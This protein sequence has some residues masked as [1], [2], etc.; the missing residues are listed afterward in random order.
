MT[1]KTGVMLLKIKLCIQRVNYILK[2]IKIEN[3]Y[4]KLQTYFTKLQF[5]CIYDKKYRLN[6]IIKNMFE[7]HYLYTVSHRSEYTPSIFVNI[8]LYT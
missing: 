1:L 4:F 7:C 2:Y 8:I 6:K 5:F 3:C